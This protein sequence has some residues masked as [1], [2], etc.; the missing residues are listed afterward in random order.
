VRVPEPNLRTIR[1]YFGGDS[2]N[3]DMLRMPV[4]SLAW[5]NIP[6]E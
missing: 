3:L 6:A 1:R 5:Q 4:L 2:F